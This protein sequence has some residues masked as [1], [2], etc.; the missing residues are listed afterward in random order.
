ILFSK[1]IVLSVLF[2]LN[3][4][5]FIFLFFVFSRFNFLFCLVFNDEAFNAF[6]QFSRCER[7]GPGCYPD[8]DVISAAR[9]IQALCSFINRFTLS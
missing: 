7:Y 3:G 6:L 8:S 5:V 4:F 1:K 2:F 9:G